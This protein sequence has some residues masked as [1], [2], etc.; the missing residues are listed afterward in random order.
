MIAGLVYRKLLLRRRRYRER[1]KF[2]EHRTRDPVKC[3]GEAIRII[4]TAR[5]MINC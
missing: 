1:V 5:I 4:L 2:R 3:R